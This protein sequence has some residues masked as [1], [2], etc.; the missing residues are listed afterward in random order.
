MTHTFARFAV[1]VGLACLLPAPA[2]WA[3][4][5]TDVADA[6]DTVVFGKTERQDLFDLYVGTNFTMHLANGKITREAINGRTGVVNADCNS[7]S[8]SRDCLPVDELRWK[9]SSMVLDLDA[10]VG[11]FHDLAVTVGMHYIIGDTLKMRYAKGVTAQSSSVTSPPPRTAGTTATPIFPVDG[12]KAAHNG[13]GGMYLG[14]ARHAGAD[15][16][17]RW[18]PLND[19]RDD[20]KPSWVLVFKWG[21]PWLGETWDPAERASESDPGPVS[22]GVH[23]LTFGTSFSKRIGNFGLIG[24][25][26]DVWR[27]GYMDPYMELNYILPV[28]QTSGGKSA[29]LDA[30]DTSKTF[31]A[32]PSHIAQL[33]GGVEIVALEDLKAS[34]KVAVDLGIRTAFFS[35]GRNYSLMSDPL[36]EVTY[37]E[38]YLNITGIIGLYIQA[39]EFIRF[40]A[41]VMLGYNTEHFLTFGE[42]GND[43][44][45]DGQVL[46]PEQDAMAIGDEIN[47]YFCGNDPNDGCSA[48]NQ[49]SYDQVGFRFKDEEHTIFSWFASL[50]LTF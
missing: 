42:V 50:T 8:T 46:P 19:E 47:P 33:N 31:G 45:G 4:E 24:I 32:R 49:Q 21:I 34:R 26:P 25:D 27:R 41:G 6:A 3:A 35:E 43:K 40:K 7:P 17:V 22:D 28:P 14:G 18:A 5:A 20:S 36:G 11:V 30:F 9:R 2:A 48:N 15:L 39:A 29:A 13:L 16:G 12:Y 38:Q 44:N 23:R 10:Q 1:A 37:T